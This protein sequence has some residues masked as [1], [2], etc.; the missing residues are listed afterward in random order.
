VAQSLAPVAPR[1]RISVRRAY[2]TLLDVARASGAGSQQR[3][4]ALMVGLL[5]SIGGSE[6]KLVVRVAQGRLRLGVG[7]QTIL[8]A[9]AL[10]ALADRSRKP[11][12]EHAYNVRSDL[13]GIVD[14][15][16]TKG[17]RGLGRLGPQPGVPVRP[18]LAQR[19]PSAAAIVERLG[20][21][22]AEPKYDGL[23]L[24]LHRDG[25]RVWVFSRR[26]ENVTGMFPELEGLLLSSGRSARL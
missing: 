21:V 17:A 1:G 15:A 9:A 14:V 26:L 16:F 11:V 18:A 20:E 19:L 23:R 6:A 7:D 22:H 5:R 24:Q 12:L 25:T 4:S 2:D 3:K 8:E 13:G 10:G